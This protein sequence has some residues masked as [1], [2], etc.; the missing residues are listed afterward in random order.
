MEER[1]YLSTDVLFDLVNY[2]ETSPTVIQLPLGQHIV[3]GRRLI[4]PD[5]S[6]PTKTSTQST[7]PP[8]QTPPQQSNINPAHPPIINKRP[9]R[10][11]KNPGR[12]LN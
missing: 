12:F 2:W 11:I 8:Q 6:T 1:I 9:K 3:R 5:R 7:S 10:T 4:R